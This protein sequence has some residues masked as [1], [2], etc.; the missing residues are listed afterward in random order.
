MKEGVV[1]SGSRERPYKRLALSSVFSP[2]QPHTEPNDG[3]LVFKLIHPVLEFS[4]P[5]LV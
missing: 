1:S 5:D 4:L 3:G 2:S